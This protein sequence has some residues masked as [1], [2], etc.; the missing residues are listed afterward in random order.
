MARTVKLGMVMAG[1]GLV[2]EIAGFMGM[3]MIWPFPSWGVPALVAGGVVMAAGIVMATTSYQAGVMRSVMSDLGAGQPGGASRGKAGG[4]SGGQPGGGSSFGGL[5]AMVGDMVRG[6]DDLLTGGLPATAI[7][8]SMRDTG[9][10]VNDTP[11][12][13]F[14]LDVRAEGTAPYRVSHR[15][16]LPRLLVGAVLPGTALAVRVDPANP[17]RLTVDWSTFPAQAGPPATERLSAADLIARGLPG[18]ATVEGTF[19][20]GGMTAENGDPIVGFVLRVEPGDGRAPYQ[21]RIGHRVPPEHLHRTLPGT[22]LPVRIAP[23]DPEKVA[24]DWELA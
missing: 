4:F 10:T 12:V 17:D 1:V 9:M 2:L 19:S 16:R 15:E 5:F 21:V 23:E 20:T 24:V 13:A 8:V 7:V 22:R 18:T 3:M 11:V 6:N 14:E